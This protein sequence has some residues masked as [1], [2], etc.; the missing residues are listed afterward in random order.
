MPV[1]KGHIRKLHE[2]FHHRS[3]Q[4]GKYA[5]GPPRIQPL[6]SQNPWAFTFSLFTERRLNVDSQRCEQ[7]RL[8]HFH[9]RLCQSCLWNSVGHKLA[10]VSCHTFIF[11]LISVK[12]EWHSMFAHTW[13]A[14]QVVLLLFKVKDSVCQVCPS[15]HFTRRPGGK[16]LSCLSLCHN[17]WELK[18]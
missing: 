15:F 12:Q 16:A 13:R 17:V 5:T 10:N 9:H 3:M 11:Y 18:Q 14:K 2:P 7:T 8:F 1:W 6:R 4:V